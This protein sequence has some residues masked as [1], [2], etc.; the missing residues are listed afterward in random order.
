[1][2]EPG[3]L[4]LG[5]FSKETISMLKH[6]VGMIGLALALGAGPLMAGDG[7]C[8][9]NAGSSAC[10]TVCGHNGIKCCPLCGCSLV[11]VC[12][13]C[14]AP[15]TTTMHKHG[16][17]CE[18]ICIPG[19]S[20]CGDHPCSGKCEGGCN[21]CATGNNGG[22]EGCGCHC[23]VREIHKLVIY[24][25]TKC[26]SVKKCSVEWVCPQCSNQ[27]AAASGDSMESAKPAVAPQKPAIP[28]A[29]KLP[30]VKAQASNVARLPPMSL[31][32]Q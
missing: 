22:D 16:C 2:G 27:C 5:P 21:S 15:K 11:P 32:D 17:V 3:R 23:R 28:R 25:A 12:H 26:S 4:G 10:N 6:L 29:P 1:M 20:R 13:A 30:P 18:E 19:V 7:A 24:P 31:V 14:C 9:G 8:C